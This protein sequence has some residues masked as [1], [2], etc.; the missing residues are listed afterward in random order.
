MPM[1]FFSYGGSSMLVTLIGMGI[2][3]NISRDAAEGRALR[4]QHQD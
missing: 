1:P 3:L 2:L 4:R